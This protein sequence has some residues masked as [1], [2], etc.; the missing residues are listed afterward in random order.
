MTRTCTLRRRAKQQAE[1][2]SR[3]VEA[4]VDLHSSVGPPLTTFTMVAEHRCDRW[5]SGTPDPRSG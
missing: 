1:T 3:I 4:A 5:W 2:R